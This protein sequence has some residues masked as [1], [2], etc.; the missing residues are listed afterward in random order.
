MGKE[1]ENSRGAEQSEKRAPPVEDSDSDDDYGPKPAA[2]ASTKR[3]KVYAK[4]SKTA[5]ER[6]IPTP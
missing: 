1:A 3:R 2:P 5:N 4:F 6:S